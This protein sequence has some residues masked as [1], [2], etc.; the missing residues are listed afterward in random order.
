MGWIGE[1]G[2]EEY[3]RRKM[4]GEGKMNGEETGEK[5]LEQQNRV[6]KGANIFEISVS[7]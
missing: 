3:L 1:L 7:S 6:G 5:F 2:V 4:F